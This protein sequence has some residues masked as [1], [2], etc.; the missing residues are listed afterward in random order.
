MSLHCLPE[1]RPRYLCVN[2]WIT[3]GAH[4][5]KNQSHNGLGGEDEVDQLNC[6]P[7]E[8]HSIARREFF[9]LRSILLSLTLRRHC[10][11]QRQWE[12]A[13]T[14]PLKTGWHC[15]W[16]NLRIGSA[17]QSPSARAIESQLI[18][19]LS[20][21]LWVFSVVNPHESLMSSVISVISV[22][23][24]R[25]KNVHHWKHPPND[26]PIRLDFLKALEM[27]LEHSRSKRHDWR[28][29]EKYGTLFPRP[30]HF[31]SL[32]VC[33]ASAWIGSPHR[34]NPNAVRDWPGVGWLNESSEAEDYHWLVLTNVFHCF[35]VWVSSPH[36]LFLQCISSRWSGKDMS[37][38][39]SCI[40]SCF[41]AL[42]FA[43]SKLLG[44]RRE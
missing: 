28:T 1:I 6:I 4:E 17:R 43:F 15:H 18:G 12:T 31:P 40:K 7:R 44:K 23:S 41:K 8:S 22:I 13:L 25:I 33:S 37:L 30:K 34:T 2:E 3:A 11:R 16:Q 5:L 39:I 32:N 29:I 42:L 21:I 27:H 10:S 24:R 35:G 20:A 19:S 36:K 9:D 14:K 26:I 38:W